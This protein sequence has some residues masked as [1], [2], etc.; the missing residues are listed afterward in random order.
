MTED[1][2]L[3]Q[4]LIDA[5][6]QESIADRNVKESQ[7]V[8]RQAQNNVKLAWNAIEAYMT[9]TGEYEL[10]IEGKMG[11]FKV[12]RTPITKSI[13]II[14]VDAVPDEYLRIKKEPDKI[15]IKEAYKNADTLPNWLGYKHGGGTLTWKPVKKK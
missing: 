4:D 13:D 8:L 2:K 1:I 14:D 12:C 9:E 3:F 10:I 15:A 7:Q 6:Q 5:E 11:N